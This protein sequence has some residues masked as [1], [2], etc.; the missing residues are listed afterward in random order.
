MAHPLSIF[1]RWRRHRKLSTESLTKHKSK[2]IQWT[3]LRVCG[4]PPYWMESGGEWLCFQG[5]NTSCDQQHGG[6]TLPY[7]RSRV[8]LIPWSGS[9]DR[10]NWSV[11]GGDILLGLRYLFNSRYVRIHTSQEINL[12]MFSQITQVTSL[13][14][15]WF[16][17]N[18]FRHYS[19]FNLI[20]ISINF[21]NAWLIYL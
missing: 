6:T 19:V 7:V 17:W 5:R 21:I 13:F 3:L 15:V 20:T 2:G 14:E 12:S 11:A 8:V 1:L 4:P 16:L 18:W 9:L 10:I